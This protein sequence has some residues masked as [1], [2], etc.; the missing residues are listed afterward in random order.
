MAVSTEKKFRMNKKTFLPI[1]LITLTAIL[2][3]YSVAINAYSV[4]LEGLRLTTAVE[5]VLETGAIAVAADLGIFLYLLP[6]WIAARRENENFW[7]IFG[8]N[9]FFG[10]TVILWVV[11][12]IWASQRKAQIVQNIYST[13][14]P[15]QN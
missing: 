14:P 4:I 12:L 8:V 13:P 15:Q 3:V 11:C 5:Y 6:T 1:L 10:E 9:L 7:L 2:L